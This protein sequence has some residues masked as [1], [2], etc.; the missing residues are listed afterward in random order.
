MYTSNVILNMENNNKTTKTSKFPDEMFG[1]TSKDGTHLSLSPMRKHLKSANAE[2]IMSIILKRRW[3]Y[4]TADRHLERGNE[5]NQRKH[6][7]ESSHERHKP[8]TAKLRH[9]TLKEWLK[10]EM[11]GVDCSLPGVSDGTG[12]V[13]N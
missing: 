8:K 2:P 12:G 7:N 11:D 1:Q 6:T 5:D 4:G 13:S 3:R 9:K 10:I